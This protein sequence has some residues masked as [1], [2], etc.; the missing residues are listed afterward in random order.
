MPRILL[1]G[2]RL[3]I[4]QALVLGFGLLM[5]LA[6]L[7]YGTAMLS[8]R[9]NTVELL[10]DRNQRLIDQVTDRIRSKLE[11]VRQHLEGLRDRIEAGRVSLDDTQRLGD[12]LSAILDGVPQ[13]DAVGVVRQD[14]SATR[15]VRT[16]GSVY[17]LYDSLT[18]YPNAQGR[19]RAAADLIREL[20]SRGQSLRVLQWGDL[21]WE[22]ALRQPLINLRAP[23]TIGDRFVGG[24]AALVSLGSL[25]RVLEAD[26]IDGHSMNFILYDDNYVLAHPTLSSHE[27]YL[28]A[29]KPLPFLEEIHDP[30]LTKI[31]SGRRDS[32]LARAV[33][34]DG[35]SHVVEAEGR[36]WIFLYQRLEGYGERPWLVGRYFP[37]D[38][39]ETEVE[40]LQFAAA[41][42]AIGL[43]LA[44]L[45]AWRLGRVIGQPIRQLAAAAGR[46]Q[47][48]EFDGPPLDRLRLREL[49]DAAQAVNAAT[50]ALSWFGNYVPRK[51]VSRL[52]REGEDAVNMSKQRDVTVLFTDIVGFT[53]ISETLTAPEVAD[54]LNQHFA[55]LA[56]HIEAE[57]GVIDKFIGDSVM[58]VWGAIKR[59]EDHAGHA[60]RAVAAMCRALAADNARRRMLD[61]PVLRIR[62]GL[63]SGP[64]VVGNIGA[65]SRMNYTVVGDTVNIAQRL[66]QLG[67]DYMTDTDDYEVLASGITVALAAPQ[68]GLDP[69][70][71]PTG[72][73]H[74]KG[75]V[76]PVE[77]VQLNATLRL[78]RS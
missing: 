38:D 12:Y 54:M 60:L 21:I 9:I 11:P 34:R 57:G 45:I 17:V 35:G 62:I 19:L 6:G 7:A 43:L 55:L 25:S 77:V 15:A 20:Q 44:L 46:L 5:L 16:A 59:D 8:G 65:P 68:I 2:W 74:V 28:S 33:G 49:D 69:T 26:S 53:S 14:L 78:I 48:L 36:R 10:R 56:G 3:S 4:A 30:V 41:I 29:E 70:P 42:G 66:E 27:Y 50:A 13:I 63:H 39:I 76:E 32:Q 75:R 23:L 22:P 1:P 52:L 51:L 67:R 61:L 18:N 64:V 37:F 31:W 47:R 58:A 24:M 71:A 72:H 40:R 73:F